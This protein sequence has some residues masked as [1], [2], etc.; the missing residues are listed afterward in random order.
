MAITKPEQGKLVRRS[1]LAMLL[2]FSVFTYFKFGAFIEGYAFLDKPLA[3]TFS[4]ADA[5]AAALAAILAFVSFRTIMVKEKTVDFLIDVETELRK[6]A[7]PIDT[8]AKD[9]LGKTQQLR[10]SSMV[11]FC[12]ILFM[13]GI[14]FAYDFIFNELFEVIFVK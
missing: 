12:V 2:L 8:E 7:W 14:L 9:F 5:I 13:A 4:L 6:V 1:A 10:T 3:G 11:V